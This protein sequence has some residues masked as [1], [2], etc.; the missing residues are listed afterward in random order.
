MKSDVS[1]T[2]E[3]SEAARNEN[4]DWPDSAVYH[5]NQENFLPDVSERQENEAT[6]SERNSTNETDAQN[7]PERGDN[8]TV[9]EILQKDEGNDNLSP[10]GGRYN[11]RPNPPPNYSEDLRY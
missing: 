3:A 4:S 11:L 8:I 7:S 2:N 9:P 6:F 1:K 10:R 5:K